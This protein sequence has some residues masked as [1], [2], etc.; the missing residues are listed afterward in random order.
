M[1]ESHEENDLLE[2]KEEKETEEE[3][4]RTEPK[5][6]FPVML[7]LLMSLLFIPIFNFFSYLPAL[8]N[9]HNYF[10][11]N[12][13]IAMLTVS[14]YQIVIGFSP[15]IIGPSSDFFGRRKVIITCSFCYLL[16]SLLCLL[17][18]DIKLFIIGRV[19]QGFFICG[20]ISVIY[21]SVSEILPPEKVGLGLSALSFSITC[22]ILISPTIG[23]SLV[24]SFTWKGLFISYLILGSYSIII[25][26]FFYKETNK[27]KRKYELKKLVSSWLY[28]L[29]FYFKKRI[30]I[31]IIIEGFSVGLINFQIVIVPLIVDKY[32]HYSET[33]MGLSLIPN[34]LG[35]LIGAFFCGPLID[36]F[37][38][39]YNTVGSRLIVGFV[40]IIGFGITFFFFGFS[41]LR[42]F[43]GFLVCELIL[44]F[45]IIFIINA[46]VSFLFDIY[47]S[48][49]SSLYAIIILTE[50]IFSMITSQLSISALD[51]PFKW[52]II[53]SLI[54]LLIISPASFIILKKNW[55]KK[56]EE[57]EEQDENELL[58]LTNIDDGITNENKN[59]NNEDEDEIKK[60][61]EIVEN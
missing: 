42:S 16:L 45:F 47:P 19:I 33:V 22:T 55:G 5:S 1:S 15:L 11:T 59:N 53:G 50:S 41:L 39:K 38:K 61:K 20:E 43:Y 30:C 34:G 40:G 26:F 18:T 44:N 6:R 29:K 28:P 8:P 25:S 46:T 58:N 51:A 32:Y 27:T 37:Y 17:S 13:N 57:Q 60:N 54:Q 36:Y 2:I 3:N 4:E 7:L 56:R 52:F 10:S 48:K 24:N 23:G 12:W 49:T 31:I 9:V 35:G 14:L 21:A